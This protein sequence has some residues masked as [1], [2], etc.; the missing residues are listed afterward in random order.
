MTFVG[1]RIKSFRS[2]H[3]SFL[4]VVIKKTWIPIVAKVLRKKLKMNCF[5]GSDLGEY[6][7]LNF[8]EKP[9]VVD[10]LIKMFTTVPCTMIDNRGII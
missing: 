1:Y 3:R 2:Q 7:A 9:E 5:G 8:V 10:K 6:V 4:I